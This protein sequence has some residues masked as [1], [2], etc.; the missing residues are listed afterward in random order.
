[1]HNHAP[2]DYRCPMCRMAAGF[3]DE[4]PWGV[5]ADIVYRTEHTFALVNSRWW[6]NNPG[7]V[8]VVPVRHVENMYDLDQ[9]LAGHIHETARQCALAM[10]AIYPCEGVSTRQ[11]NE[12]AGN[13]DVFHYHLHVFPRYKD[14]NLYALHASRRTSTPAERAPYAE[15][16]RRYFGTLPETVRLSSNINTN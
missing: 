13:Q 7:H 2:A 15:K 4:P 14:D 16:L 12:P 6:I 1:M 11:H 8:L 3:D 5:Q 9:E 10:K